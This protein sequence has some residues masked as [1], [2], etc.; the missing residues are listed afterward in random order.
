MDYTTIQNAATKIVDNLKSIDDS[1][2]ALQNKQDIISTSDMSMANSHNG[3]LKIREIGGGKSEQFTTTGKNRFDVNT[4]T[5]GIIDASTGVFDNTNSSWRT[6]DYISCNEQTSYCFSQSENV[7]AQFV[8]IFYDENKTFFG[9]RAG[10]SGS[11]IFEWTFVTPANT[12]YIRLCYSV[13]VQGVAVDRGNL[14]LELG[15]VATDYEPYTGGIPAPNPDYPQ[16]IK[17]TVVSEIKTHGKNLLNIQLGYSSTKNGVTCTVDNEGVIT[18]NGTASEL[19]IFYAYY[20]LT[21]KAGKSYKLETIYISGSTSKKVS[22]ANQ[23][24]NNGWLGYNNDITN[25]S[26]V[27]FYKY[28]MDLNMSDGRGIYVQKDTV[29]NNLKF[30]LMFIQTEVDGFD[31]VYEPYTETT[32]KL[33]EPIELYGIGDVKDTIED[34]KVVRRFGAFKLP[35]TFTTNNQGFYYIIPT[36]PALFNVDVTD[37]YY[38][39]MYMNTHFVPNYTSY[40]DEG[41]DNKIMFYVRKTDNVQRIFVKSSGFETVEAFNEYLSNN[42][43]YLYYPLA[44]EVTEPLPPADQIALNNL[45]TFDTVTYL[46]FDSEIEPTFK[47]EY[48]VTEMG[49]RVLEDLMTGLNS[50]ILAQSDAERITALESTI[51][52][53]I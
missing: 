29:I 32:I 51:V 10:T 38:P 44:E 6:S 47:G 20:G 5:I 45:S 11:D 1:I 9:K 48:G 41:G 2:N 22:V 19:T 26:V 15:P 37:R 40:F 12:S 50:E 23:D 14:Q 36:L 35:S 34:G 52:N 39:P 28:D 4:I 53:N 27:H 25:A 43:V 42:D 13:S 24:A 46:E 31:D 30:K 49:G 17:K 7:Y 8:A 33:S 18:L 3:K 16:E 21:S